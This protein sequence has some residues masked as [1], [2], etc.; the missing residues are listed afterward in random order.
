MVSSF[1]GVTRHKAGPVGAK[2][3]EEEEDEEEGVS[4]VLYT[5]FQLTIEVYTCIHWEGEVKVEKIGRG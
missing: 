4:S 1:G 3:D 5:V 2:E